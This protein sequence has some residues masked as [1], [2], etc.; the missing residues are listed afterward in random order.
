MPD[1]SQPR[2]VWVRTDPSQRSARPSTAARPAMISAAPARISA[3]PA[4]ARGPTGSPRNTAAIS[5]ALTG[6]CLTGTGTQ[7]EHGK[8]RRGR[9]QYCGQPAADA[10]LRPG[11]QRERDDVVQQ[12]HHQEIPP[13]HIQPLPGQAQQ[14][15]QHRRR[16]TDTRQHHGQAGQS[17][18]QQPEEDERRAPRD[19]QR[20]NQR[21]ASGAD[22][23]GRGGPGGSCSRRD[24]CLSRRGHASP[25]IA[26]INIHAATPRRVP[27]ARCLV[28]THRHQPGASCRG[29]D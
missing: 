21:P 17:F 20:D 4:T 2:H 11:E 12:R 23:G 28:R 7:H 9:V 22:A 19:G 3:A 1:W 14:P 24:V 27:W 25:K 13:P 26:P 8:D 10:V 29:Q 6:Q 15:I 5:R 16:Q 18:C